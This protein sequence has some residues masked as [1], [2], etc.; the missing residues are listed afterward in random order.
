MSNALQ[1]NGAQSDKP[2]KFS[3]LYT[4]RFFDGIWTNRSPLR[5]AASTRIEEKFYGP[6]GDAMIAGSNVEITNRLTL[7]RRPGNPVYDTNTWHDIL[8]FDDF[9]LSKGLSDV[10][11]TVTE[12]VE[13]MVDQASALYALNGTGTRELVWTKTAGAGQST[14]VQ[15]GQEWYFGNGVDNKKWLQSLGVRTSAS[16][17]FVLNLNS[18]P[19]IDTYIVD[20][21]GNIQQLIGAVVQSGASSAVN[22]ITATNVSITNNILTLT[23]SAAPSVTQVAGTQF[24]LWGFT[25]S[26]T[27]FL[28]GA[29][30]TL[31]ADWT[32]TTITAPLLYTGSLSQADTAYIQ[33]ESGGTNAT[34]N[35]LVL[36]SS[37]PTWGTTTP[38]SGNNFMGSLTVDGQALWLNRGA[39]VE[40]WGLAAPTDPLTFTASGSSTGWQANTY[41][42]PASVF[43]DPTFGNLWQITTAGKLGAVMPSWPAAPTA[44]VKYDVLSVS[45]SANVVTIY[46]T[47]LPAV[48]DVITMKGLQQATFLNGQQLTVLTSAANHIT[49]AFTYNGTFPVTGDG[50]DQGYAIKYGTTQA[51]GAATWTSLQLAASLTWAA[52]THYHQDD[53]LVANSSLF[54]LTKDSQ[55][56]IQSS[57]STNSGLYSTYNSAPVSG[58]FTTINSP[59]TVNA[60]A[61][62]HAFAGAFDQSYG[63]V[64]KSGTSVVSVPNP[65]SLFAISNSS[66]SGTPGNNDLYFYA[67]NGAGELGA[68]TDTG[69]YE[70]WEASFLLKMYIPAPGNYTFSLKHDDGAFFSFDNLSTSAT[71]VMGSQ[72][73]CPPTFSS[74]GGKTCVQGFTGVVGNNNSGLN[75]DSATWSFPTAGDYMLEINWCN[76]EHASQMVFTCQTQNPAIHPDTS[77]TNPPSFPAFTATGASYNSTAQKIVWGGRVSTDAGGQ[78]T[79]SNLG[80]ISGYIW[81][82]STPYTLPSTTIVDSNSNQEGPYETGISGIAAPTW[83]SA[84]SSITKETATGLWWINEGL[85]PI[86]PDVVGKITATSTQGWIYAIAL[87]NTL[88]NTVSNIGPLSVGTGPVT[89]G[90][91]TFAPGAGL[92]VNTIDPQAD[93]VAIFRTT[94][95]FS[96]GLLIPSNGNTI[97]TVPLTQ[98]LQYGYVDA[99]PDTSLDDLATAPANGE[100]TPPLPGAINLTYHLNRI[101]YSV[102]NTVYYTTG[103]LAPVGNGINGT[104]PLNF[105]TQTSLVTRLMPT[106]IG[107]LVF[108]VSDISIIPNQG[109]TIL[110]S[111]PYVPGVGLSSY[112]ALDTS[113]PLVGFFSTDHQFI[114]FNP[115]AGA[116][117]ISVPIG[118]QLRQQTGSAP[119]DWNPKTAY[120]AWYVNGEDMGWFLADGE[121]GWFR[122]VNN[123]APDFGQSWSPFA[124]I[125]GGVTAIK[126]VETSPGVHDLLLGTNNVSGSDRAIW[127]RNLDASSDGGSGSNFLTNGAQYVAYGVFGS[128]VLAQPGQVAQVAFVTTDSV[129]VGTPL[130]L[131]ILI[132]EALPYYTGSFEMLK[133]WTNDPPG[134]KASK[135]ILGQR[136]YLS[137]L[138]D[139]AAA[140]RHMQIMIQ[141]P[142]ESAINELQSFTIFGSYVQES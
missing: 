137:E 8:S 68:S 99:T 12:Q 54:Q 112:N 48:S 26:A 34:T 101:W 125:S 119:T 49:A 139:S 61:K 107:L 108:T 118:D 79:W 74:S 122:L 45:V 32:A 6:R 65:G 92:N 40:N 4:G 81:N 24:M 91:V 25:N 130:I 141:W 69:Q 71:L 98:Y 53:F 62:D 35:T 121:H 72:S 5:D 106:A 114:N 85:I 103:P 60:W 128:Y 59:I 86:Q 50:A 36:G 95:G 3:P 21:N 67:V 100:N 82:A 97:Y 39:T 46:M 1:A 29:T 63:A 13:V 115:S 47:S 113:G 104:A 120:V 80:A 105:D 83:S 134:L 57:G 9:R 55:P 129:N 77:G 28:N 126:A 43:I 124:T 117:I 133:N 33:I 23:T 20:P 109:G 140:C 116:S 64:P 110:P 70:N 76:W 136:F 89:S 31:S 84:I 2:T 87:V 132:D 42:S 22:N 75:T 102:G 78:Y 14:G 135:S 58:S 52:H 16:N 111:L 15:V 96:T 138:P 30:I 17:N 10:F 127:Y 56:F 18:Y 88:D 131:G 66:S 11:G 41:Y 37:V 19:L 73:N 44:S 90:H 7:A 51:D 123:P 94:D 38:S 142:A 93:Y 27:K